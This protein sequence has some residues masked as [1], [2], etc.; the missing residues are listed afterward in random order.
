[1]RMS[2]EGRMFRP[3]IGLHRLIPGSAQERNDK[4]LVIDSEFHEKCGAIGFS[5]EKHNSIL[6][7]VHSHCDLAHHSLLSPCLITRKR[8]RSTGRWTN[9]SRAGAIADRTAAVPPQVRSGDRDNGRKR[10]IRSWPS[11]QPARTMSRYSTDLSAAD[12]ASP[13]GIP[14]VLPP[15]GRSFGTMQCT[16]AGIVESLTHRVPEA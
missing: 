13:Q 10:R 14:V 5:I 8:L 1:V 6:P 7:V 9:G 15:A 16:R 11:A 4:S 2:F 3:G 12:P